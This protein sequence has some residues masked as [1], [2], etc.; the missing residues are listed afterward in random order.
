MQEKPETLSQ[1]VS[2][3][4]LVE[5]LKQ[6]EKGKHTRRGQRPPPPLSFGT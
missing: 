4:F 1:A 2:P 6:A 3:P 5:N